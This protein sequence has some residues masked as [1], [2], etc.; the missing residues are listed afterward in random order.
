MEEA[1]V[2]H[3]APSATLNRSIHTSQTQ[4]SYIM[5]FA[6]ILALVAMLVVVAAGSPVAE[7]GP[8]IDES[9]VDIS[10][11]AACGAQRGSCFKN[12]GYE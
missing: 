10:A 4:T 8:V 3:L 11:R 1:F 6:N 2:Q 9:G 5:F 7:V 12:G